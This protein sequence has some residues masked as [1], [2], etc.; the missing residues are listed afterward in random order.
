M[1]TPWSNPILVYF[2]CKWL[3]GSFLLVGWKNLQKLVGSSVGTITPRFK[4]LPM[5][6]SVARRI[7]REPVLYYLVPWHLVS[8][9]V[10]WHFQRSPLTRAMLWSSANSFHTNKKKFGWLGFKLF[11]ACLVV[12][13]FRTVIRLQRRPIPLPLFVLEWAAIAYP[14]A[15]FSFLYF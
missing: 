7:C 12:Q 10:V 5:R 14:G 8:S 13:R 6:G 1:S 9:H 2:L 3:V 15:L 4:F 11:A